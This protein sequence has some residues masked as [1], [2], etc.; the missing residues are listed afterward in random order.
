[1]KKSEILALAKAR[2]EQN[3]GSQRKAPFNDSASGVTVGAD[4]GMFTN[5]MHPHEISIAKGASDLHSR[6]VLEFQKQADYL[7]LTSQMTGIPIQK[8]QTYGR[9]QRFIEESELKKAM[10]DSSQANWVPTQMSAEFYN[11]IQLALK[12]APLFGEVVMPR[13]PFQIP[14]KASFSTATLKTEASNAQESTVGAGKMTLTAKTIVD[15]LQVSYELDEDAAFAVAPMVRDDS[16][17]AVA[18]GIDNAIVN[19]D[20]SVTNMDADVTLAY[21]VRKAWKGLRKS[22]LANGYATD[23]GTFNADTVLSGLRGNMKK[24][25]AAYEQLAYIVG[26]KVD[27]KLLNLKDS[28]GNRIYLEM[29]T[30]GAPQANMLPGQCAVLGGSPVIVS[31]FAREDLNTVGVY[32]GS[33]TVRGS[34]ICVRRDAWTKGVVRRVMVETFRDIVAQVNKLV[35]STRMDFQP[36]YD[37]TTEPI[38]WMGYNIA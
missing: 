27:A 5:P 20:D 10:T 32:D 6:K 36:K 17:N 7:Y 30:P 1:M 33:S 8:M 26:P 28:S 38:V 25:G 23:L 29:G 34:L 11:L 35:V 12:V 31:E 4:R 24:Y 3:N 14:R 18:R 16:V 21:D 13:S 37:I 19:G 9:F 22:A 15:F 2:G